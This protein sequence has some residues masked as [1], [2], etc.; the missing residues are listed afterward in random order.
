MDSVKRVTVL[1][2]TGALGPAVV[3]HLAGQGV[4]V[5]AVGRD[6]ARL[7]AL[8]AAEVRI[9]DFS[10]TDELAGALAGA[11][12]V[13]VCAHAGFAPGILAA[14]PVGVRQIVLTGSTRVHTR[15]PDRAAERVRRGAAAF[16]VSAV[17]GVMLH[18]TMIYGEEAEN[19]VRRLA[20]YIRTFGVIPL[21]HG[22]RALI[23]PIHVDDVARAAVAALDRRFDRPRQV[24]VAG[25]EALPYAAFVRAVASAIG[26]RIII[27][28]VP[29]P[30]LQATAL[31]TRLVPGLPTIKAAE[32]RRLS[33]DKAFDIAEMRAC[34]GFDPIPLEAGLT[35]IFSPA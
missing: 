17:P 2:A 32:I 3:R 19:N 33:E 24:V 8:P 27:V 22:G 11:E 31:L 16:E 9:A 10:V 4:A 5:T 7:S 20:A 25:P 1:G 29:G 18:P 14:L 28:P 13:V 23:Q 34:F 35:R 21:P 6:R 30:M 26:R 12:E 15:F